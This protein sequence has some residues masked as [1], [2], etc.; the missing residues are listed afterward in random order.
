ML[1]NG[2]RM[3]FEALPVSGGVNLEDG[4]KKLVEGCYKLYPCMDELEDGD[5]VICEFSDGHLERDASD[6]HINIC[7]GICQGYT[8]GMTVVD[9]D[10][11]EDFGVQKERILPFDTWGNTERGYEFHIIDDPKGYPRRNNFERMCF[12]V[13]WEAGTTDEIWD[14]ISDVMFDVMFY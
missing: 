2:H 5:I 3:N 14:F 12:A 9:S 1:R 8:I 13:S 10:D 7:V 11:Y 4:T 6:E